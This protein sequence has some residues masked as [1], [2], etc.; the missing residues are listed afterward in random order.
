MQQWEYRRVQANADGG[1]V[2]V[3]RD[4]AGRSVDEVLTL[5][6]NEG[7][8]LVTVVAV[9]STRQQFYFKRPQVG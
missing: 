8:E 4:L 5:I 7:W 1:V 9:E 3:E 2:S 6:G